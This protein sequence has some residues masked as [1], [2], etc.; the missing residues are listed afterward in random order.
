MLLTCEELAVKDLRGKYCWAKS[1]IHNVSALDAVTELLLSQFRSMTV[2]MEIP[3]YVQ[4]AMV[5]DLPFPKSRLALHAF[6]SCLITYHCG[7][8]SFGT[9][10]KVHCRSL[11]LSSGLASAMFARAVI[12]LPSPIA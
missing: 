8:R 6:R 2:Y 3:K 12:V 5:G 9:T 1:L 7:R 10:I 4:V 11:S